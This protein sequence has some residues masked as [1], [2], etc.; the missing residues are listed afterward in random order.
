VVLK[1]FTQ[2]LVSVVQFFIMP[3]PFNPWQFYPSLTL[4]NLTFVASTMR[5]ARDGAARLHDAE[6]GDSNWSLGCRSYSRIMAQLRR[7]SLNKHWLT[8]LPETHALRFTFTVGSVPL[9]FYKGNADDVPQKLLHPSFAELRQ[10]DLA[11]KSDG[12]ESTNLLR[13]A[14]ESDASGKTSA[15]TLVEVEESGIP[16]RVFEI[17]LDAANVIVMMPKPINLQPPVLEVIEMPSEENES[18]KAEDQFGS[19]GS[20]S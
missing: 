18:A 15:V 16:I 19:A 1:L 5:E 13:I 12:A 14:I 8:V 6:A 11:F 2:F 17:P 10:M 3:T 7:A 20:T 4:E 9:K